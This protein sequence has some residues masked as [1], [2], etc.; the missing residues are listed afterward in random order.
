MDT[1]GAGDSF[2]ATLIC[3]LLKE[4][5]P[6]K[7]LNYACAIGAMVAGNKGANPVFSNTEIQDFITSQR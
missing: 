2:L 4:S 6:E 5:E 1:V 3:K 7:S